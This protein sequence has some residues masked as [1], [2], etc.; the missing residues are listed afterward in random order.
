MRAPREPSLMP[1]LKK[2][3]VALASF[4]LVEGVTARGS[5]ACV[6]VVDGAASGAWASAG[7]RF[8]KATL[9]VDLGCVVI[10]G[11]LSCGHVAPRLF[12]DSSSESLI[13]PA[14]S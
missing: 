4:S 8:S 6:A 2:A 9:S 13:S 11:T 5:M 1:A 10:V 3:R 14:A 12:F 7:E